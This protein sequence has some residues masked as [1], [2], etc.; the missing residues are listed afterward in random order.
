[1]KKEPKRYVVVCED[2]RTQPMVKS[3]AE[4]LLEELAEVQR[5]PSGLKYM[6][7]LCFLP[8]HIEEL[9]DGVEQ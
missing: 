2:Y 6:N 8:H 1:V 7:L 5:E 9:P 3:A 4:N